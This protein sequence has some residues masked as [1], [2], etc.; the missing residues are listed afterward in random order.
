MR[1]NFLSLTSLFLFLAM[2]NGCA[3]TVASRGNV[4]DSDRLAEIQAGTS[5][6]E[7]VAT[8]M[9]TP[10]VVSAFDDKIWYYVGRQTEQYS[11]FD[12][13]VKTQDAVVVRFD[14]NGVVT[15]VKRLDLADAYDVEPVD[16]KTPTYGQ[17]NTFIQQLLGNLSRPVPKTK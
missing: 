1:L 12:P 13:Q 4:L 16:R 7:D 9:G 14:D 11:F 3:P 8:K 10:T 15:E 6:R 17:D 2:V 5:T